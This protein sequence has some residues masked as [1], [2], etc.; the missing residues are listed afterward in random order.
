VKGR[1]KTSRCSASCVVLILVI[2]LK[3]NNRILDI[4]IMDKFLKFNFYSAVG[5]KKEEFDRKNFDSIT[6]SAQKIIDYLWTNSSSCRLAH[7]FGGRL[8]WNPS[9]FDGQKQFV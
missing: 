4:K 3:I 6:L 9:A 2:G 5:Q 1:E 8:A 7:D